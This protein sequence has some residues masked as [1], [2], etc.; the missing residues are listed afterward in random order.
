MDTY[1]EGSKTSRLRG[2]PLEYGLLAVSLAALALAAGAVG[3][4]LGNDARGESAV[5]VTSASAGTT[6][7]SAVAGNPVAGKAVF[8]DSGCSSCHIFAAAGARGTGGPNLDQVNLSASEVLD[9]VTNGKGAMPSFK[10]QVSA[11][12]LA[13]VAAFVAGQK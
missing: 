3:W 8:V 7:T 9:W 2:S 10:G 6:S 11:K 12:K 1:G 5:A 13:D 4:T